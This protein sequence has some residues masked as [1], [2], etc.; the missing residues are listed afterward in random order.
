M[1]LAANDCAKR[2][3]GLGFAA[4][5][6]SELCDSVEIVASRKRI[7]HS[8]CVVLRRIEFPPILC[9]YGM[10]TASR[11]QAQQ[12]YSGVSILWWRREPS[13]EKQMGGQVDYERQ[14]RK[15]A[16]EVQRPRPPRSVEKRVSVNEVDIGLGRSR[17]P[18]EHDHRNR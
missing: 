9:S 17:Q 10:Y 18:S 6:S 15:Y 1:G 11:I 8:S 7:A 16:D 3:V 2:V 4:C 13:A 12:G 5:V 14:E